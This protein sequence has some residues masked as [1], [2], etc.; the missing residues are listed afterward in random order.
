MSLLLLFPFSGQVDQTQTAGFTPSGNQTELVGKPLAGSDSLAGSLFPAPLKYLVGSL[1]TSGA[2]FFLIYQLLLGTLTLSG[3][4]RKYLPLLFSGSDNT[5]GDVEFTL[6]TLQLFEGTL[7]L[8]G[9]L[10]EWFISIVLSGEIII[11]GDLNRYVTN[12]LF[13]GMLDSLNG[14]FTP[15]FLQYFTGSL[16]TAGQIIKTLLNIYSGSLTT[17]GFFGILHFWEFTGGLTT[18]GF[19]IFALI[20]ELD[21]SLSVSGILE[22][23]IDKFFAGNLSSLVGISLSMPELPFIGELTSEG[24][25]G[26]IFFRFLNIASDLILESTAIRS[27]AYLLGGE[28]FWYSDLLQDITGRIF[29]GEFTSSSSLMKSVASYMI[30]EDNNAGSISFIYSSVQFLL[31]GLLTT[32]SKPVFSLLNY[33]SGELTLAG[34]VY[35][36]LGTLLFSGEIIPSSELIQLFIHRNIASILPSGSILK[37]ISLF[38]DPSDQ[39]YS[40]ALFNLA[41][42]FLL[43]DAIF[44]GTFSYIFL[45][46]TVLV[47]SLTTAG[48]ILKNVSNFIVSEVFLFANTVHNAV[49]Y[50]LGEIEGAGE[51]LNNISLFKTGNSSFTADRLLDS[52]KY[53][54]GNGD[55]IADVLNSTA[56]YFNGEVTLAAALTKFLRLLKTG[57]LTTTSLRYI[58]VA[59]YAFGSITIIGDLQKDISNFILGEDDLSGNVYNQV[60]KLSSSTANLTASLVTTSFSVFSGALQSSGQLIITVLNYFSG[61]LISAGTVANIR[62]FFIYPDSLL[63]PLGNLKRVTSYIFGGVITLV[64]WF[65]NQAQLLFNASGNVSGAMYP[66]L[67]IVRDG[68]I[69]SIGELRIIVLNSFYSD[70]IFS[71]TTSL[72]VELSKISALSMSG[73][74]DNL[75][76]RISDGTFISS[77]TRYKVAYIFEQGILNTEGVYMQFIPLLVTGVLSTSKL[78]IPVHSLFREGSLSSLSGQIVLY[79]PLVIK[80][81]ANWVERISKMA[82]KI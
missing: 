48:S 50:M 39:Q 36:Y 20:F 41:N 8:A 76:A 14:E 54:A 52:F 57:S 77:S 49:L 2:L 19:G 75:R 35:K 33:F 4:I 31:S 44:S 26:T 15:V 61:Q 43:S 47:G 80:V 72:L 17:T 79:K 73:F 37:E 29:S 82:S 25:L 7:T 10:V 21:S 46:T 9:N 60:A 6:V 53:L 68:S 69:T 66:A 70:S 11:G 18:S 16:T 64:G 34:S 5:S 51:I 55:L 32:G 24:T 12:R 22:I 71:G 13:E 28:G 81:I 3:A 42:K 40:G 59:T 23:F 27:I 56:V 62:F 63:V 65:L 1:T 58:S 74:A 67:Q 38:L 45:A 78:L 30:G